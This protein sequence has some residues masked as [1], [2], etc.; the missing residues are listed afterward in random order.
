[1]ND[2]IQ[3]LFTSDIIESI[4]QTDDDQFVLRSPTLPKVSHSI[5]APTVSLS[6]MIIMVKGLIAFVIVHGPSQRPW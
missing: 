5:I 4:A 3:N 2:F 6:M 1:M